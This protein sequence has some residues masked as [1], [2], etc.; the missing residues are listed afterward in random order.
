MKGHNKRR[1]A[2]KR[3]HAKRALKYQL[4]KEMIIWLS[5]SNKKL[6]LLVNLGFHVGL[7]FSDLV[8]V[9]IE[10]IKQGEIV[11]EA[12]K[13]DE[14]EQRKIP[15]QFYDIC[16]RANISLRGWPDQPFMNRYNT[17]F[18][19]PQ[20][21]IREMKKIG[22]AMGLKE[23]AVK[24]IATHTMRKTYA[25]ELFYALGADSSALELVRRQ[26]NHKD[27]DTTLIYINH[28][29]RLINKALEDFGNR[30]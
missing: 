1:L 9:T 3:R 17:R 28:D 14:L 22:N 18:I 15:Q 2:Q 27:T 16:T 19:T 26:M 6:A 12:G 4:A 10:Q 13:N 8:K 23:D 20:Y 29:E 5:G 24:D 25:T 30:E 7:R 21:V 11:I